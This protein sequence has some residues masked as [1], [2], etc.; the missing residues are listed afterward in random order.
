M[1]KCKYCGWDLPEDARVCTYCGHPVEPEDDEQKRRLKLKWHLRA[2][3]VG[4][5]APKSAFS[6]STAK[7][8]SALAPAALVVFLISTLVLA[9]IVVIGALRPHGSQNGPPPP[10]AVTFI[11]HTTVNPP[12]V[13]FGMVEKGSKAVLPMMIKTSD[14]SQ[15]K[16]EV[17]SGNAQWLSITLQSETKEHNNL[18]DIIYD[19]TAN[20]STLQV[21]QYSVALAIKSGGE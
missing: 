17:E 7:T 19:V 12:L 3:V 1:L 14:T 15:F 6:L 4:M 13:D 16:L 5:S 20:T 10:T 2:L 9:N 18:R 21:G 11:P 8:S